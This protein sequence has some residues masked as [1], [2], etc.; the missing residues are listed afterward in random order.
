M[1]RRRPSDAPS[2][3]PQIAITEPSPQ[4]DQSPR[5]SRPAVRVQRLRPFSAYSPQPV[6]RSLRPPSP[7]HPEPN[8]FVDSPEVNA[9]SSL[10]QSLSPFRRRLERSSHDEN[11]SA[12][13]DG[14]YSTASTHD[15]PEQPPEY[16]D[17]VVDWLDVLGEWF[18]YTT[19]TSEWGV[20]TSAYRSETRVGVE[21][22]LPQRASIGAY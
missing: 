22:A 21:W 9:R 3:G 15:G 8:P 5:I 17:D 7:S 11:L 16:T 18:V 2:D 10:R 12:S 6:L 19:S 1:A 4:V 14:R 20:V 13:G